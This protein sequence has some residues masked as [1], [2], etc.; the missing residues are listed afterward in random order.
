[1][2]VDFIDFTD[3]KL[4]E[5][6]LKATTKLIWIETPSNPTMKIIDIEAIV[7]I[8]RKVKGKDCWILADNTFATPYLQSPLLMGCDMVRYHVS[9]SLVYTYTFLKKLKK[10]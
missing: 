4:V 5:K 8:V 7:K 3:L 10:I 6:S 9:A 2:N 1:M